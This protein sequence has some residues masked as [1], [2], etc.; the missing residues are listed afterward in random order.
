MTAVKDTA[1]VTKH[2]INAIPK[3]L[4]D[5]ES[6]S[7]KLEILEG[8]KLRRKEGEDRPGQNPGL[9]E[10]SSEAR[11]HQPADSGTVAGKS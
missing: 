7:W 8:Q 9:K 3:D 4:K 2:A 1:R 6:D 5:R 10:K 11:D